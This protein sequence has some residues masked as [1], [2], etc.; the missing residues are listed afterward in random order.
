ML[1]R[2]RN[3]APEGKWALRVMPIFAQEKAIEAEC[4]NGFSN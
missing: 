4:R 3:L 1:K 2:R